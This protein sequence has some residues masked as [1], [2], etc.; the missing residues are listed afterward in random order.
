MQSGFC[1]YLFLK[2]KNPEPIASSDYLGFIYENKFI[3]SID[4][5]IRP[6]FV[7]KRKFISKIEKDNNWKKDLFYLELIYLEA[8]DYVLQGR[9][10][11]KSNVWFCADVLK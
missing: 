4:Q 8:V 2:N 5:S 9:L 11:I 7:L 1:A 3:Q 6:V 10:K